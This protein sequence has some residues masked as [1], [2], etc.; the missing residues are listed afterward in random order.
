MEMGQGERH[1]SGAA[2]KVGDLINE[3]FFAGQAKPE[4]IS[5]ILSGRKTPFRE[6][7]NAAWKA[8][9]NRRVITQQAQQKLRTLTMHSLGQGVAKGLD[10]S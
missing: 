5:D 10:G 2:I 4:W 8:Q 9:Y 7:A 6:V 1:R 3:Q